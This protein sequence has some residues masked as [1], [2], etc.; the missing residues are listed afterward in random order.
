MVLGG[1]GEEEFSV[2]VL[3]IPPGA[4]VRMVGG[5]EAAPGSQGGCFEPSQRETRLWGTDGALL[6]PEPSPRAVGPCSL[7][8]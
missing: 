7:S 6:W 8:S 2:C 1:R 5:G 4:C 3:G